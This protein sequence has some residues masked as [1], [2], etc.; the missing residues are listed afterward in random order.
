[1]EGNIIDDDNELCHWCKEAVYSV[2]RV[3][4]QK[5]S[6]NIILN[7]FITLCEMVIYPT[8]SPDA[9]RPIVDL[10]ADPFIRI[11]TNQVFLDEKLC[12]I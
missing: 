4:A 8:Y 5:W 6:S 7:S 3:F 10:F 9:C 1:L 12:T 2:N 11:F